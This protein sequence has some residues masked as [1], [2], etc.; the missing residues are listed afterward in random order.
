MPHPYLLSPNFSS[1]KQKWN[2]IL[3]S[4]PS[5]KEPLPDGFLCYNEVMASITPSTD[6]YLLQCPLEVD[7]R[8]QLTFSNATEQYNYFFGLPKI[9]NIDFSYQR[10]DSTIRYNAHIDSIRQYNYC[11]YRNDNYSNQWFYAFI[12]DMKYLND[13]TTLIT[14]MTDVWQTWQFALTIKASYVA[15]EHTNNDAVGANILDE[16]LNTGEYIVNSFSE[17]YYQ[18][19]TQDYWIAVQ[20]SDSVSGMPFP[21]NRT[22]NGIP[23]G[24]WTL[25]LDPADAQ[26]V[27]RFIRRFDR[28]GKADAITAMYI[29]PKRF[30]PQN[31]L[32]GQSI[33]DPNGDL[34]VDMWYLPNSTT[35][36]TLGTYW[37]DRNTTINGYT[38]KNN[39]LFCYPYNYLMISNNAGDD[40]VYHWEDFSSSQAH[41]TMRGVA[42]Q[43]CQIRITPSNYKNTNLAGGYAWSSTAS[44][45][46]LLSWNSDY[47]LNWQAKNG[48]KS[49]YNA[50]SSY[51]SDYMSAG[52]DVAAA[53]AAGNLGDVVTPENAMTGISKTLSTFGQMFSSI[54]SEVSGGYSASITPDE[55]RGTVTGDLTYSLGKNSF[56]GYKMSI[57]AEVARM[58]DDYFSMYGY[59]TDRVKVPNVY[60]RRNWNFVKT[61]GCNILGNIPQD[62]LDTIKSLFNVGITFWHNPST[63]LDYSQN[64]AIV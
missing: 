2:N 11:M 13:G 48:F 51:V 12:T 22:Y 16:G 34:V 55:T 37:W 27:N 58:I 5:G 57:K 7:Q 64:N 43:G 56:V 20:L 23:Q 59:R 1:Q 15:R 63:Y 47:Y 52:Q 42:T 8:N 62:D 24:C 60:G 30:A 9:G 41:F 32:I 31:T 33:S 29:L 26:N 17:F 21:N 14:I 25:L 10:K 54:M 35:A 18:S 39:K 45:I 6:L 28:D 19:N 49:G 38:P 61:N 44:T 53:T 4:L 36:T 46:P 50:S 40:T 3:P